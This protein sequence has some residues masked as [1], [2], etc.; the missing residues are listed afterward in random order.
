VKCQLLLHLE[1][2]SLNLGMCHLELT[3]DLEIFLPLCLTL[4][5]VLR[6]LSYL[7]N[8]IKLT[9]CG[10]DSLLALLLFQKALGI[11]SLNSRE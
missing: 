5:H 11:L 1:L 9:F 4:L 2:L 10:I 8:L 3:P 6:L 7:V